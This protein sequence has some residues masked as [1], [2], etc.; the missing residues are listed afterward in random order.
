MAATHTHRYVKDE[1]GITACECGMLPEAKLPMAK[2]DAPEWSP[3]RRY[4]PPRLDSLTFEQRACI[5]ERRRARRR[6]GK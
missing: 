2:N 6:T 1:L 5:N 3:S 4:T